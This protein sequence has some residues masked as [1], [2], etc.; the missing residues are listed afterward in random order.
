M[1]LGKVSLLQSG[2]T[3]TQP[4]CADNEQLRLYTTRNV[5]RKMHK[6]VGERNLSRAGRG[7][8]SL[9]VSLRGMLVK[10]YKLLEN[11]YMY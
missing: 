4:W 11:V 7:T 8:M 10:N 1:I 3:Q 2:I 6:R 5:S 9:L